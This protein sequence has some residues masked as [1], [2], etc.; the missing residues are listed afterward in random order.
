MRD[1]HA[2]S[3]SRGNRYCYTD[4]DTY[5]DFN[6]YSYSCSYGY[7]DS[8]SH[9]DGGNTDGDAYVRTGRHARAVD[10]GRGISHLG[11]RRGCG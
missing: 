11:V 4:S 1:S 6:A 8:D 5:A 10:T 2:D 3:H 9:A 7:S